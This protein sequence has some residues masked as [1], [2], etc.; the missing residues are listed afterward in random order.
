MMEFQAVIKVG[1][2]RMK[3]DFSDGSF[4]SMSRRPATHTTDNFMVQQAI[5]NSSEFK[6]GLIKKVRVIDL[7]GEVK[8]L[9]N[10]RPEVK[11]DG[12]FIPEGQHDEPK[13]PEDI[14][15]STDQPAETGTEEEDEA[16]TTETETGGV[17]GAATD[18]PLR[19]I[20]VNVSDDARDI[21]ET[22]YG[23]ARSKLRT[24]AEIGAAA[25]QLG[26]EFIY[27]K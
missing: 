13:T 22:E 9:R 8:V 18:T 5:E 4:N 12:G 3:I 23:I 7:P 14:P 26:I 27:A 24:R 19:Q 21:L 17:E 11:I 25:A 16:E 1:K 2:A 20:E 6:R 15:V 10:R